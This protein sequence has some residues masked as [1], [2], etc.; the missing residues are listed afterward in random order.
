MVDELFERGGP[1]FLVA[2]PCVI[3]DADMVRRTAEH[4]AGVARR[5]GVPL[6]FKASYLK[7]NRTSADAFRG[8]GLE[9]GL[10][11]LASVKRD[12]G[13]P[14]LSDVHAV[15][16]VGPAAEV[17]D[18]LQI[19]AFLCRQ[20]SLVEAAAASGRPLNVKK[21]QFLSPDNA[22]FVIEKARAAGA[23]RVAI[24]ER[25]TSFG[26]G[27]LIVDPRAFAVYEE[28]GIVSIYDATHSLQQP[29]GAETGGNRRFARPLARAALAAGAVG[30]FF[31]THPDPGAAKSDRAT[32]LPLSEADAFVAEMARLARAL[33]DLTPAP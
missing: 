9:R 22:Q 7:D 24:T 16:E 12:T 13:L 3:E 28:A 19:P 6:I 23:T 32:Q 18:V 4:L 14:V 20:S 33:D 27:D 5:H 21:G 2:G 29:G 1:F 15:P 31:E 30:L 25:G 8:P 17:L 11:V 26:Y 10:S